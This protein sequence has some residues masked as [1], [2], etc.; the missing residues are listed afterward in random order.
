MI[1]DD[2]EGTG[3]G[4][5][6]DRFGD[7]MAIYSHIARALT[8]QETYAVSVDSALTLTKVLDAIRKS[9]ETGQVIYLD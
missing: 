5:P 3:K 4:I 1:N 9:S 6:G 8:G 7:N 2:P